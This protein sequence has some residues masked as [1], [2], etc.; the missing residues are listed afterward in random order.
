MLRRRIPSYRCYKPKN[1][2]LVVLDG[3]Q[4]YL[5]RYGS[6]ESLAEYHRLVQEWLA[7][8]GPSPI[9][10]YPSEGDLSINELI[11]AFWT[12]HAEAHYRRADGT[13]RAVRGHRTFPA[14]FRIL[15]PPHPTRTAKGRP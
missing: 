8:G 13:G 15:R 9:P 11:L 1:L 2:G 7:R 3:K 10:S 12:R 4:H 6:P 5:G 14:I